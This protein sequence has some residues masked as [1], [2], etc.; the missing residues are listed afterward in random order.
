[1]AEEFRMVLDVQS[2]LGTRQKLGSQAKKV[3]SEMPGPLL[4]QISGESP[5]VRGFHRPEYNWN[6]YVGEIL[7]CKAQDD[8]FNDETGRRERVIYVM[9]NDEKMGTVM[10]ELQ[11]MKSIKY[12]VLS[13]DVKVE[14]VSKMPIIHPIKGKEIH[15]IYKFYKNPRKDSHLTMAQIGTLLRDIKTRLQ[16]MDGFKF[17]IFKTGETAMGMASPPDNT[18]EPASQ[19]LLD[20]CTA[21]IPAESFPLQ[22]AST[23]SPGLPFPKTSTSGL[24]SPSP[25]KKRKTKSKDDKEKE[26]TAMMTKGTD[27]AGEGDSAEPQCLP[28]RTRSYRDPQRVPWKDNVPSDPQFW[29]L[30][31]L[32]GTNWKGIGLKLKF[33]NERIDRFRMDH[34][35]NGTQEVIFE[36]FMEWRRRDGPEATLSCLKKN[37]L[38]SKVKFTWDNVPADVL[39]SSDDETTLKCV[40]TPASGETFTET[41]NKKNPLECLD[42]HASDTNGSASERQAAAN[43]NVA[44]RKSKS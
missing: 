11:S 32:F 13:E 19:P 44:K 18:S 8:L 1:M 24:S 28:R 34:Q 27:K 36:M 42:G 37:I 20:L 4:F 26:E 12:L 9:K 40:D 25:S 17:K 41:K 31:G 33:K 21:T 5:R 14:V 38:A 6:P 22:S 35:I 16:D 29:A 2:T 3:V 23:S 7:D 30:A 43:M 39:V 15:V 10:T